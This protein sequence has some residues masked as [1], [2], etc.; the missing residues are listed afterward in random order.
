MVCLGGTFPVAIRQ[1]YSRAVVA[2]AG[3]TDS[4]SIV[5]T[6]LRAKKLTAES[7]AP[8]G[9]VTHVMAKAEECPSYTH[10]RMT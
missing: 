2:M 5:T 6:T 7:F 3:R 10:I 4:G 9:Q 1:S 8:Y